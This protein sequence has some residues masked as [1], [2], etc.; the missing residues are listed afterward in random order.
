MHL[1][2]YLLNVLSA[3]NY[4][5]LQFV[6]VWKGKQ[7]QMVMDFNYNFDHLTTIQS[8][9]L[10]QIQGIIKNSKQILKHGVIL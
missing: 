7:A 1:L 9:A 4:F 10:I 5:P 3:L 6:L 2:M 8:F